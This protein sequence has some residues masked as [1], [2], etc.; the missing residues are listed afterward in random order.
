MNI[1][2]DP[3]KDI[4]LMTSGQNNRLA[5]ANITL[6]N[7]FVIC[8]LSVMNGSKGIF[9]SM[10]SARFTDSEGK[11]QYRDTAFP[12][13]KS[14]RDEISNTVIG[15]YREK[16]HELQES[17][18]KQDENPSAAEVDDDMEMY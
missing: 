8:N 4:R 16:L 7:A 11:T 3:A 12:L 13:S 6:D 18:A 10:P 14:L 17:A 15:A 5:L 2:C 9:V 1:K